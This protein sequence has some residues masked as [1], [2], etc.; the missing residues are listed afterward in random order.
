MEDKFTEIY[1]KKSGDLKME[2]EAVDQVLI[3]H[4]ILNGILIFS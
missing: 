4:L 2:K 3:I 1:D